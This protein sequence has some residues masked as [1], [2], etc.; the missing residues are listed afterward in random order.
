MWLD[1]TDCRMYLLKIE[2]ENIHSVHV[3]KFAGLSNI[4]FLNIFIIFIIYQNFL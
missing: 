3:L 1:Q 2:S 4:R